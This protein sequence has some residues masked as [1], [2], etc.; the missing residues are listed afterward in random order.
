MA[1]V[2]IKCLINIAPVATPD[3]QTPKASSRRPGRPAGGDAAVRESLLE[4]GRELLLQQVW[5]Y[6]TIADTKLVNV[7]IQRL[8]S[9]RVPMRCAACSTMAV[10]AGLMP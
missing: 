1:I 8:R 5:G 10:T 9:A 3:H 4:H 6:R 2:L 7:H